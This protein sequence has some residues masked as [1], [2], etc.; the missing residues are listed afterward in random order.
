MKK[1]I[2]LLLLIGFAYNVKAQLTVADDN[3][4]GI[5]VTEPD[6]KLSVNDVGSSYSTF[7]VKNSTASTSQRAGQ[8]YKDNCDGAYSFSVIGRTI[9]DGGGTKLVGAKFMAYATTAQSYDRTYGVYGVAGNAADGYNYGLYGWLYGSKNGAAVFG[10]TDGIDVN[11]NDKWAG[12]FKGKVNITSELWVA[13]VQ[14]TSDV[15]L[16]KEIRLLADAQTRQIDKIKT[17]SAIKYK[18]KTP[19]ELNI[20]RPEQA[21]TLKTDLHA[22]SYDSDLYTKD[23]IGLSAQDVQ[24]IYPEL[25]R[26]DNDGFLSVNYTGLIPVLI[27]GIKEQDQSLS[28]LEQIV[29]ANE[30][31]IKDQSTILLSQS[32][33]ISGLEESLLQQA[34]SIQNLETSLQLHAST[35]QVLEET[36]QLQSETIQA[37]D[38]V[39]KN[40]AEDIKVLKEEIEKLK[41]SG[42]SE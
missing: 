33:A 41:N 15:N 38:D 19:A 37:M 22:I 34:D 42:T 7:Y 20:V 8:F 9:V 21:D 40:Q 31:L 16:K 30:Q 12:Y 18:L 1:L 28:D 39:L 6:S 10:C 25:V 36:V 3:N 14:V 24:Q 32:E 13:G 29:L 26:E 4:V 2:S 35:V 27:E 11:V 17:L 23:Q 5:G